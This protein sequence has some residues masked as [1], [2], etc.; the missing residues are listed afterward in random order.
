MADVKN[1]WHIYFFFL[2][3]PFS[4][5]CTLKKGSFSRWLIITLL[6]VLPFQSKILFFLELRIEFCGMLH[7]FKDCRTELRTVP[8]HLKCF[9]ALVGSS[10]DSV[11]VISWIFKSL[12]SVLVNRNVTDCR[13]QECKYLRSAGWKVRCL[14]YCSL[15]RN[16]EEQADGCAAEV[17]LHG[18][19]Q[20]YEALLLSRSSLVENRRDKESFLLK[21]K[22]S[23]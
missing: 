11:L 4:S 22:D 5:V 19:S 8:G 23:K 9:S 18:T 17:G 13:D 12:W 20:Q 10:L 6:G 21:Q 7:H 1:C 3:L 15:G 16:W 14:Q 2:F